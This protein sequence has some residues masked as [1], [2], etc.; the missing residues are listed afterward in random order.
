MNNSWLQPAPHPHESRSKATA[1]TAESAGPAG[2]SANATKPVLCEI[3]PEP[4]LSVA[5]PV[6]TP[7]VQ[8]I[9]SHA[10]DVA[11]SEPCPLPGH[12]SD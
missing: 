4:V 8:L 11:R 6:E 3:D 9:G 7:T 2:G 5:A 10:E 12:R 1:D